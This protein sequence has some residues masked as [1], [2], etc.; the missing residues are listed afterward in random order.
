MTCQKLTGVTRAHQRLTLL[1]NL[2]PAASVL[3]E[4]A[5]TQT[6][7]IVGL[8]PDP[9]A[10]H[11]QKDMRGCSAS[12]QLTYCCCG[13]DIGEW[14]SLL[15]EIYGCQVLVVVQM[16]HYES[17]KGDSLGQSSD[18]RYEHAVWQSVDST[19]NLKGVPSLCQQS[20]SG[21][22]FH[23]HAQSVATQGARLGRRMSSAVWVLCKG[24]MPYLC[25][26]RKDEVAQAY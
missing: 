21:V 18:M 26:A 20:A 16:L 1:L 7:H 9:H 24:R 19:T 2:F 5:C 22:A 25:S 23:I 8:P 3:H 6:L 12:S 13:N 4:P 14:Q 10:T 15:D 17:C 11:L